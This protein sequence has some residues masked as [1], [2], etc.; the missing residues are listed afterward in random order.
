MRARRCEALVLY[1]PG[2]KPRYIP[3]GATPI[4]VHHKVTRARGGLILDEAGETYHLMDLCHEHH[5]YAHDQEPAYEGGLMI[6]GYVTT[7]PD[8]HPVYVGPDEYLTCKYPGGDHE[9]QRNGEA[10]LA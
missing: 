6:R 9:V 5:M 1:H 4:E 10:H 8:G 2:R 7:G 3:C